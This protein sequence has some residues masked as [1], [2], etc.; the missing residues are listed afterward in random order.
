MH[1]TTNLYDILKS[2]FLDDDFLQEEHANKGNY[3]LYVWDG[4]PSDKRMDWNYSNNR[5]V[6]VFDI[7]ISTLNK[8]YVCNSIQY[9]E[10]I[11][12]ESD[13]ILYSDH[14]IPDFKPLQHHILDH[15]HKDF[16][17]KQYKWA[18]VHSHEV[19]IP[20]KIPISYLKSVLIPKDKLKA[21]EINKKPSQSSK[22]LIACIEYLT[23]KNI[24]IIPVSKNPNDFHKYFTS[25]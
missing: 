9:G 20:G 1:S 16:K 4:I 15:I 5:I 14:T 13:R 6:L 12:D 8:L 22:K 7:S 10:C 3:F 18:Y 11:H 23:K 19:V 2:G 17:D 25:I 24:K 21:L